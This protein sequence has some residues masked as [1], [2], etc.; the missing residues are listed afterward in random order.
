M[1]ATL[2]TRI[3]NLLLKSD[4]H[5]WRPSFLCSRS[6]SVLW[7]S[8]SKQWKNRAMSSCPSMIPS[9]KSQEGQTARSRLEGATDRQ[10]EPGGADSRQPGERRGRLEGATDRQTDRPTAWGGRCPGPNCR[11][12]IT[13]KNRPNRFAN[14]WTRVENCFVVSDAQIVVAADLTVLRYTG[15]EILWVVRVLV[16]WIVCIECVKLCPKR[17]FFIFV[18]RFFSSRQSKHPWG[19]YFPKWL[20]EVAMMQKKL[21]NKFSTNLVKA[22][23]FVQLNFRILRI[24]NF[25]HAH[26]L[27]NAQFVSES[28]DNLNLMNLCI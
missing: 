10:T 12:R 19:V 25:Y 1:T 28:D 21:K 14:H 26:I 4:L 20:N 24:C 23:Q 11:R 5:S 15:E 3:G 8:E 6:W 27:S 9:D 7:L 18:F 17:T 16:V 13:E 2:R 22:F